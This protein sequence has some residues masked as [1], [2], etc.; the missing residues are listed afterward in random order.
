MRST[1]L[2]DTLW[3]WFSS[4]AYPRRLGEQREDWS[5]ETDQRCWLARATTLAISVLLILGLVALVTYVSVTG[6]D[7]P[8]IV[9]A[10]PLD[11]EIRHEG[12]VYLL[13]VEATNRGGRTAEEVL[14]KAAPVVGGGTTEESEFTI[15]FLAGGETAEGTVVFATDP[16]SG[17]LLI[18]VAS[19]R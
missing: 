3:R 8:P 10:R 13:P 4:W 15:D 2:W 6:G 7:D 17:D 1:I 12:E 18:D 19:F 16:L 11:G 9:E 5:Y 14:I